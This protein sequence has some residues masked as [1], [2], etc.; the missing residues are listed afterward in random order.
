MS[1]NLNE[2]KDGAAMMY[3]GETPWHGLGKKLEAAATSAEAIKAAKLDW[4]VKKSPAMVATAKGSKVIPGKFAV[5]REDSQMPLGVV[6]ERYTPLQ[7]AEAFSF[8]DAVVGLK[9]AI[10]HTAGALGE[11]EKVWLL[12]KLPGEVKVVGHDISEKFLLLTNSHDGSGSV[13]VLFTPIR[14]VCQNT[15]NIALSA[16]EDSFSFSMR[17]TPGMGLK[18]EQAQEALGIV[19]QRFDIFQE[20]ARKLATVDLTKKAV[21]DY[22]ARVANRYGEAPKLA[23]GEEQNPRTKA[24]LDEMTR[25]FEQGRGAELKGAK[26]TA[27]G[28]FNAVAEFVDYYRPTVG[29]TN[30]EVRAGR[31]DSLL[32][33]T[34]KAMKQRAWDEALALA[35]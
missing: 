29:S 30:F 13:K 6:G 31:A 21:A 24:M 28:A 1:H 22:F 32:F 26:G 3:V 35:K 9:E 14:V 5:L 25:L 33:G 34:G 18:V 20:A 27:W 16:K 7:N 17:H 2:T 10:Y 8:F 11:G 15:L 19:N 4:T 23:K 12:A